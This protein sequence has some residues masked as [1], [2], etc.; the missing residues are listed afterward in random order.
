MRLLKILI[1]LLIVLALAVLLNKNS[2]QIVTIW[3]FPGFV[4]SEINL[5]TALVGTLA[6]GIVLGFGIGL[7]QIL[8]QQSQVRRQGSQLK[9]L[10]TELNTLRHSPL[11]VDLF[12]P[13]AAGPAAADEGVADP[14][15]EK[16]AE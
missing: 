13:E 9:K 5:T 12:E 2:D 14:S 8:S 4:I 1:G 3:L 15:P 16:R 6:L 11:S 7:I 10:R